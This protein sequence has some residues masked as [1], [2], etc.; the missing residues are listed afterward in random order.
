[1]ICWGK[2]PL[3][4]KS[5]IN[6]KFLDELI[7]SI[8]SLLSV[9]PHLSFKCW[10][11]VK[12]SWKR[13]K[14]QTRHVLLHVLTCNSCTT[15]NSSFLKI[16]LITE[17]LLKLMKLTTS[18]NLVRHA[19]LFFVSIRNI[20]GLIYGLFVSTFLNFNWDFVEEV[21]SKAPETLLLNGKHWS[22]HINH[23]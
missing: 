12:M 4:W 15:C 1:M 20:R 18:R 19:W 6:A 5:L 22:I 13:G 10:C 21:R 23:Q 3:L 16:L 2:T 14:Q 17:I 11:M 8:S 7:G 9:P